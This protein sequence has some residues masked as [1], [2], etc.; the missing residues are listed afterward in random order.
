MTHATL[1]PHVEL[2]HRLT[3]VDCGRTAARLATTLRRHGVASGDRVL[4][5][6][7]NSPEYVA[8]L[9]AL[10]S[11]DASLVLADARQT[12]AETRAV[13]ARAR[14]RWAL[15][16]SGAQLAP[17]REAL[18]AML[19]HTRV[20]LLEEAARGQ[21]AGDLRIDVDGPWRRRADAAVLWSSGTTGQPKGV[22]RSGESLL[23]N[24]R[25][26][27]RAMGYRADDV[28]FPLLP[29]SHQYGMSLVLLW[30]LSGC[31]LVVAPY[32]GLAHAIRA[33]AAHRV[34]VVD[35]PP[36]TYY[37]LLE[38][39]ESSPALRAEVQRVRMWC[40]GGAPLPTSLA[41]RFVATIGAP[42]LDGYGLSELGNVAL[43]T[44]DNP[45]GCGRPIDGVR[46]RIA[47]LPATPGQ[48]HRLG[49][50][51]VDSPAL[52]TGYLDESGALRPPP[53]GWFDTGDLGY[54]DSA[55]NLHVTGRHQAIHRMGYTLYPE[56]I[57][58]QAAA[59]GAPV[60]VIGVAD[61][62]RGSKL[63][64]F[65]EDPQV[66]GVAYWRR[67]IDPLLA[68]YERPDVI[69]VCPALPIG[70]SGKVNRAILTQLMTRREDM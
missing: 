45:V 57:Q 36:P 10:V 2:G 64:L 37:A 28:L 42:L 5:L 11:L 32:R 30:W 49:R 8:A 44:L 61:E 15:V 40:V 48:P 13:A 16:G 4:L 65:V 62:R 6:G 24:T 47:D 67:R 19:G 25:S 34:T 26:T 50:V 21:D 56:S 63:V 17:S 60:C 27:A 35:A 12:P 54:V 68:A 43:A 39:L 7:D 3:P 55:G 9:L 46:I 14:A 29:F 51:L 22:V 66:R 38:S 1:L 41:D 58:A 23:G 53:P 70:R 20:L 31:S 69:E 18:V 52:M 59:C 33:I